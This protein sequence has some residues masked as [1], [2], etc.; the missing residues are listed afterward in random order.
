MDEATPA[1]DDEVRSYHHHPSEVGATAFGFDPEAGDAA[2]DLAGEL[3]S[4]FL[5]SATR[6]E[7]M[8]DR[9]L[10][11]EEQAEVDAALLLEEEPNL[12]DLA[13]LAPAEDE[14]ES[15]ARDP[16]RLRRPRGR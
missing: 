14:V 10:I 8:S 12:A 9:M 2:A 5:E 15:E 3:G 6:G 4:Q 11:A 7:D 13:D 1:L 16:R